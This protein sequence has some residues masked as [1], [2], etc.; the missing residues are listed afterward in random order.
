MDPVVD[1]PSI[2][3]E[4]GNP[5][6][7]LRWDDVRDKLETA[8]VYWMASTRSDG[9]PHVVPRD[10]LWLEDGLYYGGSPATVHNRNVDVNPNV[11]V[12]IGDGHE[13]IIVEGVVERARPKID[14]AVRLADASL[15]K[16]PAYGRPDPSTYTSGDAYVLRPHLILAWTNFTENATRFSFRV[17]GA[18]P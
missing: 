3:S 6:E 13:A 7:R 17:D 8:T 2:P 9:R 15:A 11:V 18:N 16:Y 10:G 5:T 14:M 12:H 1:K 4:Y